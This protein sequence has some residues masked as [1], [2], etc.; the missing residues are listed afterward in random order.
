[1]AGEVRKT[2]RGVGPEYEVNKAG[3]GIIDEDEKGKSTVVKNL[4]QEFESTKVQERRHRSRMD[5]S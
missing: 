5:D 4:F 2:S 3:V 1:M